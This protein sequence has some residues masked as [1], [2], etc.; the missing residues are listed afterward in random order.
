MSETRRNVLVGVFMLAGLGAAG[1]VM[2][3]FGEYPAWL[4]GAEWELTIRVDRLSGVRE[5][6]LI[7]MNGVEVGRVDRLEFTDPQRPHEGVKIIARIKT[8]YDIPQDTRAAIYVSPI[9]LGR[10]RIEFVV[11]PQKGEARMLPRDKASIQG[12]M[13]NMLEDVL[14]PTMLPTLERTALEIGNL[15]AELQPVAADLHDMFEKRTVQEVDDRA[16]AAQEVTATLYTVIE[17]FDE[18]LK[19][20][21]EVMGDPEVKQGMREA[22]VNVRDFTEDGKAT[23]ETLRKTSATFEADLER[24]SDEILAAVQDARAQI[25]RIGPLLDNTAE[26]TENLNKVALQLNEGEGTVGRLLD[27]ARLYE[28]LLISIERITD[29]VDTFRRL[30]AKFEREGRIGLKFE[31]VVGPIEKDI[32]IPSQ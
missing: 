4:G 3:L 11:P 21:N 17:R 32:P 2:V 22:V 16:V 27:D 31:T 23:F 18:T 29:L 6:T 9:G 14:P 26:L 25:N 15:A 20:W 24:I 30:A 12:E 19:H 1:T 13:A 8:K 28:A 7:N 10:S 5:G